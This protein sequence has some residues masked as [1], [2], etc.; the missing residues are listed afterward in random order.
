M[1]DLTDQRQTNGTAGR[2]YNSEFCEEFNMQYVNTNIRLNNGISGVLSIKNTM[3]FLGGVL[4]V[5]MLAMAA[6][7][8]SVSEDEGHVHRVA[9]SYTVGPPALSGPP[10]TENG[11]T[12]I[13]GTIDVNDRYSSRHRGSGVLL[14]SRHGCWRD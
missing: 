7:F 8:G 2:E 10:T 9:G 14:H 5:G 6:T 4:L 3:R 13:A 12:S 11:V 1:N